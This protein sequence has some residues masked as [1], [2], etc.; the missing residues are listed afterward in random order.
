MVSTSKGFDEDVMVDDCGCD[1]DRRPF[2]TGCSLPSSED[3]GLSAALTLPVERRGD[4]LP[5]LVFL[6]FVSANPFSLK[7]P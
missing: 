1:D 4:F 3:P 2:F 5:S 7:K 6:I